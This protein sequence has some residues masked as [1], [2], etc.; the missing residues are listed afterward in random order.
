MFL[1]LR[2]KHDDIYEFIGILCPDVKTIEDAE[3]VMSTDMQEFKHRWIHDGEF[4][5]VQTVQRYMLLLRL[6]SWC[7][8]DIK[9]TSVKW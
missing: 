4:L 2:R 1:V 6:E 5:L 3:T 7:D 8:Y 9:R